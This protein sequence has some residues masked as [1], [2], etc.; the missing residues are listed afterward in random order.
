MPNLGL[1][2]GLAAEQQG[3]YGSGVSQDAVDGLSY[4][5]DFI[6]S[7]EETRLLAFIDAQSWRPDLKRRVQHYGFVYDY[8]ARRVTKAD[9]LGAIPRPLDALAQRLK[10]TGLYEQTP[11]QVIIN[12]YLPGQGIA[13][14]IDCQPC[15]GGTIASLSL[16]SQ[17]LMDFA[18]QASVLKPSVL[19]ERGSL[20]IL[21]DAARHDWRHGIA[22]RKSDLIDGARKRR[23]RRVSL[24]FRTVNI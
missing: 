20:L 14:H 17:C 16:G 3:R 5:A 21:K 8:R 9:F 15:F 13:P 2:E 6:G 22:A 4:L 23:A 18:R 1:F 24:T 10:S 19:L 11:D 12:E 7:E